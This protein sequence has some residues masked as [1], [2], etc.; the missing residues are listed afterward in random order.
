LE[1]SNHWL[2][3]LKKEKD[4]TLGLFY[5]VLSYSNI[6]AA[7]DRETD[8]QKDLVD[9][10]LYL[11]KLVKQ[12]QQLLHQIMEKDDYNI[13]KTSDAASNSD[14]DEL[15]RCFSAATMLPSD[16]GLLF[17]TADQITVYELLS[18]PQCRVVIYWLGIRRFV[19]Y[20]NDKL[21]SPMYCF[22]VIA[23]D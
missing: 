2:I 16:Q 12:N 5:P 9:T 6:H 15:K 21:P 4:V 7:G 17:V 13:K 3:V 14:N 8:K 11:Q 1:E 19:P 20:I 22:S 18:W 23:I 10:E